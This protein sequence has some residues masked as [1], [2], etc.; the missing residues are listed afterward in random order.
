VTFLLIL[1]L[2]ELLIVLPL[3]QCGCV[4]EGRHRVERNTARSLLRST[5]AQ[6]YTIRLRE[7]G[8]EMTNKYDMMMY[9]CSRGTNRVESVHKDLIAI[10]RGWHAGVEMSVALLGERR[11]R[12]N[13]KVAE[14]RRLGYPKISQYDIWL[15]EEPQFLYLSNHGIL[16]YPNV[17]N[18][19]QYISTNESF[20]AGA[21]QSISVHESLKDRCKEIENSKGTLP[22]LSRD[23]DYFSRASGSDLPY[24]PFSHA[25]EQIKSAEYAKGNFPVDCNAAAIYWSQNIVDGI[26]RMPKSSVHVQTHT[27]TF[28]RN[29]RIRD[30][31]RRTADVHNRLGRVNR[32]THQYTQLTSGLDSPSMQQEQSGT[33]AETTAAISACLELEF[34]PARSGEVFRP[35][36][37]PPAFALPAVMALH[38]A[39][40]SRVH[41]PTIGEVPPASKPGETRR[42]RSDK[43]KKYQKTRQFKNRVVA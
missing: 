27:E 24:L 18:S 26:K 42:V 33:V 21:W 5:G 17:T 19:S 37:L 1:V 30:K 20:D 29:Q 11:H 22:T 40:Y 8:T 9:D 6:F 2:M 10:V 31:Y 16:L 38:S 25:E 15:I 7:N 3:I 41:T 36:P 12:H 28:D 39:R 34:T 43:G 4:E 13:Q 35:I 14:I 23:L 32:I